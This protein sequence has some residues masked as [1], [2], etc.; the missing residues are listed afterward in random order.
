MHP[1]FM[2]Q[3]FRATQNYS[4]DV[5]PQTF[6]ALAEN[7]A[8]ADE[9]WFSTGIG[10]PKMEWHRAHSARLASAAEDLR[11]VGILPSLEIQ[12]IL[13]HGDAI[14]R[15][16]DDM[17]G[18]TW[19][20]WTGYDGSEAEECSCPRDPA[21]F[22]YF[23]EVGRIYAAW[24]PAS[25]WF[26]DDVAIRTRAPCDYILAGS[27]YRPGCWCDR[28]LA[29]FSAR[30]GRAWTREA[31]AAALLD[32]RAV[33]DRWVAFWFDSLADLVG[34]IATE[35]HAVSPETVFGYQHGA[36]FRG[37]GGQQKIFRRLADISG[38]KV[39]SRP[40]GGAYLDHE[41]WGVIDK[42][43]WEAL[44]MR[45]I[46]PAGCIETFCPEIESCPRDFACKTTTGLLVESFAALAQ[47]MDTLSYFIADGELEPPAWYGEAL[48]APL[49]AA[50]GFFETYVV[51]NAET[52]PVGLDLPGSTPPTLHLPMTALPLCP[53][54]A[55]T[56]GALLTERAAQDMEDDDIRRVL[57]GGAVLDGKT[58]QALCDR[59]F[60]AELGGLAAEPFDGTVREY[61][62]DDPLNRGLEGGCNVGGRD[63]SFRLAF[64]DPS[65]KV[66]VLAEVR[67]WEGR[68]LGHGTCLV[69][70][71]D[72][73]RLAILG[74]DGYEVSAISARRLLQLGRIAD[75]VSGGRLPCVLETPALL[76][77]F[78]RGGADGS[79]RSVAVVNP[80]IQPLAAGTRL[81][82][83]GVGPQTTFV[84]WRTMGDPCQN[85]PD[86]RVDSLL[87]L[88]RD[89][90]DALVELPEIA[91]WGAGYFIVE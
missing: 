20:G 7:R 64:S 85:I 18:K 60:A 69:E 13:G 27:R 31:L 50:R 29:D 65:A 3:R 35:V 78:P 54:P 36:V 14:T 71:A 24:H 88:E 51:D 10:F 44:Q 22:D 12:A 15:Y 61:F 5:W 37:K 70:R 21:L 42:A 63:V 77:V 33:F 11:R 75:F 6:K 79:L 25:L 38:R 74:L 26:D 28:C 47:G 56:A 76:V 9:V 67:D 80:R 55:H 41:P 8:A 17:S 87:P 32:N 34:A 73:A 16:R 72:G 23:R 39:R 53:G 1:P 84:A 89:G 83:R 91:A 43:Y 57:A 4:G 59:G 30:D 66:R 2:I 52:L 19:R 68:P 58:A 48:F 81:R 62:T 45:D 49:A 40:G 86:M 46:A 82:L 90:D